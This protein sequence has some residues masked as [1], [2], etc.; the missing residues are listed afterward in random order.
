[1][2]PYEAAD[3]LAIVASMRVVLPKLIRSDDADLL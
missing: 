3:A 1:M 2:H